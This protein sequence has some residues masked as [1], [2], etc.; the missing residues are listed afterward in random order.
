MTTL[1]GSVEEF[2]EDEVSP[3]IKLVGEV[4]L[5]EPFSSNRITANDYLELELQW[6]KNYATAY[7]ELV[8]L[9]NG[10][11]HIIT[12]Y[13]S[14]AKLFVLFQTTFSYITGASSDLVS[15][16]TVLNPLNGRQL[17]KSF[18]YNLSDVLLN[19]TRTF[20]P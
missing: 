2:S 7:K 1:L 15:S 17:V 3:F 11:I 16:V 4:S 8:Y 13:E 9:P 5:M 10:L 6:D 12:T 18:N 14:P 20:I 19:S